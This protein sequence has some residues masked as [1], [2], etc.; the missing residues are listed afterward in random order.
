VVRR[1]QV[2]DEVVVETLD[3]PGIGPAESRADELLDELPVAGD[4][5]PALPPPDRA[6]ASLDPDEG[7]GALLDPPWAYPNG[8][9]S[10]AETPTAS[11]RLTCSPAM[12]PAYL[13]GRLISTAL[14]G[15]VMRQVSRDWFKRL[16]VPIMKPKVIFICQKPDDGYNTRV[17][18][19]RLC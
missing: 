1:P 7:R 6:V 5:S 4:R 17:L 14:G 12:G 13:S 9:S 2:E 11:T 15:V 10:G 19:T 16:V 3:V 18:Q 8:S